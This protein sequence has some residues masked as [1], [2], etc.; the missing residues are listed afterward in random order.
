MFKRDLSLTK[1]H[2]IEMLV[3]LTGSSN[4]NLLDNLKSPSNIFDVTGSDSMAREALNV[5]YYRLTY[6][7]SII[8][9]IYYKFS[10]IT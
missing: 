3:T 9:L 10:Q 7:Y 6:V 8:H 2:V 5:I 4:Q 1:C